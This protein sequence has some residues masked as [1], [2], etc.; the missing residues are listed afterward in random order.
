MDI[1]HTSCFV[2]MSSTVGP[3]N[4]RTFYTRICLFDLLK[5][6]KIQDSWNIPW[7]ICDFK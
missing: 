1:A 3:R 5:Y 7:F 4:S 6:S 2:P